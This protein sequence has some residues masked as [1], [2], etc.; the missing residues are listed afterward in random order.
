VAPDRNG[1]RDFFGKVV[2]AATGFEP[3]NNGFAVIPGSTP[4]KDFSY[5]EK[6]IVT[7]P[8]TS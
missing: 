3:V 2:E 5:L 4:F 7:F 1:W 6:Q 8:G